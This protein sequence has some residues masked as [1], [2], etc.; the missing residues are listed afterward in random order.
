MKLTIATIADVES[1][2]AVLKAA[3]AKDPTL[4]GKVGK[5]L[6]VAADYINR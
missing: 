3:A 5:K 1:A 2:L 6:A 4:E